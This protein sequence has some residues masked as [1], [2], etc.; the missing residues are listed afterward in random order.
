[1]FHIIANAAHYTRVSH[2]LRSGSFNVASVII[3]ALLGG[4]L[5]NYCNNRH[6]N[7]CIYEVNEVFVPYKIMSAH[8]DR[9]CPWIPL[10]PKQPPS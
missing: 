7:D 3:T 1:M 6:A 4:K 5:H 9:L 2:D 8:L 10:L